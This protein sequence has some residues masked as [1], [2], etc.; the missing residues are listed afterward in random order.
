MELSEIE[1]YDY[2][3]KGKIFAQ[4]Q[5]FND[6]NIH[7]EGENDVYTAQTKNPNV[8]IYVPKKNLNMNSILK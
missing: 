8:Y 6:K 2:F 1:I 4:N 5:K 7:F 3:I